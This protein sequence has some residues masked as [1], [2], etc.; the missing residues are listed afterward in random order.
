MALTQGWEERS[1]RS[2]SDRW[3]EIWLRMKLIGGMENYVLAGQISD[4]I[5]T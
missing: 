5:I 4:A 1:T 3:L 2:S